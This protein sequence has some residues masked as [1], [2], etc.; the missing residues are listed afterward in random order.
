MLS[1]LLQAKSCVGPKV[2]RNMRG[3]RQCCFGLVS[4]HTMELCKKTLILKEMITQK[5]L[6]YN[7]YCGPGP[8]LFMLWTT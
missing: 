2:Q 3:Q 7:I 4:L 8:V 5:R 1:L 6:Y